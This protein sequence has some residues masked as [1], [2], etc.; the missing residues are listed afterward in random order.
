VFC[1]PGKGN[2]K[3]LVENLVKYTRNNYFL[4][5]PNFK[6]F[7]EL[8]A[9][10]VTYND[11]FCILL[12]LDKNIYPSQIDALLYS[13]SLYIPPPFKRLYNPVF[14][15]VFPHYSPSIGTITILPIRSYT[16]DVLLIA[17][18]FYPFL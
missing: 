3:G 16:R 14:N 15:L 13:K 18:G 2:E 5:Y 1:G 8:N 7:E 11:F 4:P 9:S 6:N 12:S 10:Q 17:R